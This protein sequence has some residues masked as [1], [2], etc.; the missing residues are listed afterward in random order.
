MVVIHI[1]IMQEYEM[2]IQ[3]YLICS[4]PGYINIW[5]Q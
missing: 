1:K 2:L 3:I 5:T 4:R